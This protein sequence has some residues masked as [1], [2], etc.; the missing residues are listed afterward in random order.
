MERAVQPKNT[1][2]S[3]ILVIAEE[4]LT[5]CRF[6]QFAKV[7]VSRLVIELLEKSMLPEIF[8]QVRNALPPRERSDIGEK[9]SKPVIVAEGTPF[10]APQF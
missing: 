7:L 5:D 4:N 9:V 6:L 8:A 3:L 1:E 2:E 10:G